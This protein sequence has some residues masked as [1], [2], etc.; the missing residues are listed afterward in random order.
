LGRDE[1]SINQWSVEECVATWWRPNFDPPRYPYIPA[2]VTKPK[3]QTRLYLV[4]LPEKGLFQ[5]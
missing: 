1:A 4:E 2:H 3:E 5:T